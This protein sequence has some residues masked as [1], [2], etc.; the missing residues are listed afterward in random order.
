MGISTLLLKKT[1]PSNKSAICEPLLNCNNITSFE[2]FPILA[3][4]NNNSY[5]VEIKE[6]LLIER[7]RPISHKNISSAKLFLF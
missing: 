2:K 7:D 1:K 4:G 3:N 5:G 6:N